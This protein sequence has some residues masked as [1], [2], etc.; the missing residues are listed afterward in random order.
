MPFSRRQFCEAL[1]ISFSMVCANLF[2]DERDSK[3]LRVIAYNIFG[4]TGWPAQI[5]S[6]GIRFEHILV[7]R[8]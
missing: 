2:A 1:S 6:G 3:P 4:L 7:P 5:C 8:H